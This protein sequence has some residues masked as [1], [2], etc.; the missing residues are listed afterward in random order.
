M[1]EG[2]MIETTKTTYEFTS[3][4]IF[5][6]LLEHLKSNNKISDCDVTNMTYAFRDELNCDDD[7]II[8]S[9]FNTRDE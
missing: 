6:I 5:E 9:V 8:F 7:E 4:E 2:N 1:K 3:E